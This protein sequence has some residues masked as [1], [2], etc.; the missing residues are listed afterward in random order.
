MAFSSSISRLNAA[1]ATTSL[2]TRLIQTS[3]AKN[4]IKEILA[5]PDKDTASKRLE[6]FLALHGLPEK[7]RLV[8]EQ[9]IPEK[10]LL[11]EK[12]RLPPEIQS[13][14]LIEALSHFTPYEIALITMQKKGQ[15]IQFNTEGCHALYKKFDA[16]YPK[17]VASLSEFTA[18]IHD[19]HKYGG[20]TFKQIF[21]GLNL[22]KFAQETGPNSHI[23]IA[24]LHR[25]G[26]LQKGWIYPD[27]IDTSKF[28]QNRFLEWARTNPTSI[29]ACLRWI[30]SQK[31]IPSLLTEVTKYKNL[32]LVQ[33]VFEFMVQRKIPLDRDRETALEKAV[34]N[35][36]ISIV[37]YLFDIGARIYDLPEDT[38][39]EA[40][41]STCFEM[42]E[43]LVN[44][45]V[46]IDHKVSSYSSLHRG[47]T[48][49]DVVVSRLSI[50]YFDDSPP[51][52]L[53][54]KG[55]NLLKILIYL[56]QK[57]QEQNIVFN[58]S[59]KPERISLLH[60]ACYV[61]SPALRAQLATLFIEHDPTTLYTQDR[62]IYGN[63][64]N[65]PLHTAV[66]KKQY[67]M[68]TLL[69][70]KGADV[71]IRAHGH[72]VIER[73]KKIN[74]PDTLHI[75]R[76]T[77]HTGS[78]SSY[79]VNWLS[80]HWI[81]TELELRAWIDD[82]GTYGN[83]TFA[84]LF[85]GLNI[86]KLIK[87]AG[88]HAQIDI[89]HLQRAG[90]LQKGLVYP[91]NIEASTFIQIQFL[92]WLRTNPAYIVACLRWLPAQ[93]RI[94]ALLTEIVKH[95]NVSM[96]KSA[97]EF[98]EQHHIISLDKTAALETA[99]KNAHVPIARYL[100][101]NG[102]HLHDLPKDIL[103][104][105]AQT[106]CLKMVQ[107]LV[108]KGAKLDEKGPGLS[109][110]HEGK[111]AAEVAVSAIYA[112][113]FSSSKTLRKH[114]IN[115]A[116]I[117]AYLIQKNQEQD[118]PFNIQSTP[119]GITLLHAICYIKPHAQGLE[120][121]KHLFDQN[122][123]SIH[124]GNNYLRNGNIPLHMEK[125]TPLHTAL[126]EKH[127]SMM[128]FLF[129]KGAYITLSPLEYILLRLRDP[130]AFLILQKNK[131]AVSIHIKHS[132]IISALYFN[133]LLYRLHTLI[134]S[135]TWPFF[136]RADYYNFLQSY[137]QRYN[138]IANNRAAANLPVR[139]VQ[140]LGIVSSTSL[141]RPLDAMHAFRT[142]SIFQRSTFTS[143]MH[144]TD[145]P[146]LGLL[147]SDDEDVSL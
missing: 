54:N 68:I 90:I 98:M 31:D 125:N 6:I 24:S 89:A 13:A 139:R 49:I 16:L 62:D 137:F 65:T 129:S 141:Y 96:L 1:L 146:A 38:L 27:D 55:V 14:I 40:V 66:E 36:D 130:K 126:K 72:T 51:P 122:V 79:Q 19:A 71:T 44:K 61:Q 92:E 109:L 21:E 48:A 59:C 116:Q 52:E 53:L 115:L 60:V 133:R 39:H 75:L 114:G 32:S 83:R 9:K 123:D 147:L 111:T 121:A 104:K 5:S 18:V 99:I 119:H 95:G 15:I 124:I 105:A 57:G 69:L 85:E 134:R 84:Q 81:S 97:L 25:A 4:T 100:F 35:A 145:D 29:M 94:P 143:D 86:L 50:N 103:H 101:N 10:Y 2:F 87:R 17:W 108:E 30:P 136:L 82:A 12:L 47:K 73:A 23:D 88:P 102:T 110:S 33:S 107:L 144:S 58:T 34:T 26:I 106:G 63:Y 127:H 131:G 45:G 7:Q 56:I 140:D 3:P 77:G 46:K 67:E 43:L 113:Y 41:R 142:R 80:P 128:E 64:G 28:V 112:N 118:L 135:M 93:N 117:A 70:Q 11:S 132:S 91:D 74:D 78:V 120:I 138:L 37:R 22:L 76:S 42:V 8:L 20:R